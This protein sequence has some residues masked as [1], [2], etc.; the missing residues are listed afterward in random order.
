MI[1][2]KWEGKCRD[3]DVGVKRG[4][5]ERENGNTEREREGGTRGGNFRLILCGG[6]SPSRRAQQ[7]LSIEFVSDLFVKDSVRRCRLLAECTILVWCSSSST[8]F[9]ISESYH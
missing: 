6:N 4:E 7:N 1:M 3:G 2:G 5:S 9:R 8:Q